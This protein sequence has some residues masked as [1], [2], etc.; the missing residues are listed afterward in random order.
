M[1]SKPS[2]L[3]DVDDLQHLIDEPIPEGDRVD[4]KRDLNLDSASSRA[5]V[6]KD[7]ASFANTSGGLLIYGMTEETK[8][9]ANVPTGFSP[10]TDAALESRF[11]DVL[12]ERCQPNVRVL[13]NPV[14]VPGGFCLVVDVPES[15]LPVMCI[16]TGQNRYYMRYQTKSAPMNERQVRERYARVL[17]IEGVRERIL[18]EVNPFTG[19]PEPFWEGKHPGYLSLVV[20]PS[21]GPI[22]IFNP[23]VF[24]AP[25]LRPLVK[26]ERHD[27]LRYLGLPTPRYFGCE[28]RFQGPTLLYFTR[29]HRNGVVE[30]HYT[31]ELAEEAR[32]GSPH[33]YTLS[34]ADPLLDVLEATEG[35]YRAAGYYGDL[36]LIG[37]YENLDGYVIWLNTQS[38][39]VASAP[40]PL[41]HELDSSVERLAQDRLVFVKGLLDRLAQCAAA[42]NMGYSISDARNQR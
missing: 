4:Y 1:L 20:L 11:A 5:E 3:W 12:Y 10:L 17:A 41:Q 7:V 24:Q 32:Q 16:G 35:L 25:D 38:R 27:T 33:F 18:S 23:A 14:T 8:D 15:L 39:A 42:T 13:L 28:Y 26:T 31:L 22:D 40:A 37:R 19:N 34:Q 30:F 2:Q 29:L 36:H 6:A 9:R 21:F